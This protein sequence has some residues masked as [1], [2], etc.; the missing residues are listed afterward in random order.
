MFSSQLFIQ[1]LDFLI[2]IYH[3]SKKYSGFFRGLNRKT[4][5]NI[6]T[7]LSCKAPVKL[8]LFNAVA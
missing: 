8:V 1:I 7:M 5:D 3:F 4:C 2:I 6:L